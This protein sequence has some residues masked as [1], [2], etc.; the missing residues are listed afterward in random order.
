MAIVTGIHFGWNG[1]VSLFFL[2]LYN[3]SP[4]GTF[5][6]YAVISFLSI[7]FVYR[8]IPET[9]GLNLEDIASTKKVDDVNLI[10]SEE[11]LS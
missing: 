4:P 5:G 7:F 10:Q 8:F 11:E 3:L 2:S 1:L 9:K 6:F